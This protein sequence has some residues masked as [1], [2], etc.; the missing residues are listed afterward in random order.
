MCALPLYSICAFVKRIFFILKPLPPSTA[1]SLSSCVPFPSYSK[2]NP[3]S[4]LTGPTDPVCSTLFSPFRRADPEFPANPPYEAATQKIARTTC[5]ATTTGAHR[6][7]ISVCVCVCV[8]IY[9]QPA[10]RF[11]FLCFYLFFFCWFL[12]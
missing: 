2:T 10:S 5:A 3:R 4:L 6:K 7:I 8:W 11:S 12:L 9:H 1:R